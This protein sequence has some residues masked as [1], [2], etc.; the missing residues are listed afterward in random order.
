MK[1]IVKQGF[2]FSALILAS[3]C[4]LSYVLMLSAS[5]A[6]R[7]KLSI[8]PWQ[9][10]NAVIGTHYRVKLHARGNETPIAGIQITAGKLPQGMTLVHRQS[11]DLI[12]IEGIAHQKGEFNFTV[13]LNAYGTQCV[14]Q[15][16]EQV[17]KLQVI[18]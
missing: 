7:P 8:K 13:S 2:F 10:P 18:E 16:G 11:D 14:G 6:V 15:H 1:T 12:I 17:F 4:Q 9:L 3:G 5:C